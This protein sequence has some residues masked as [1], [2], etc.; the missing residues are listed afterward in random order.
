MTVLAQHSVV[1]R[2]ENIAAVLGEDAGLAHARWHVRQALGQNCLAL[3]TLA[4]QHAES[5]VRML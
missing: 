1:L 3:L 5:A 4:K 2:E